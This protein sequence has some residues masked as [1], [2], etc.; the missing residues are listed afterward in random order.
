MD[1]IA[2]TSMPNSRKPTEIEELTIVQYVLDLDRLFY[3]KGQWKDAETFQTN[4][5][6]L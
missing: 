5:T 6:E 1:N 4:A 3:Y 2:R